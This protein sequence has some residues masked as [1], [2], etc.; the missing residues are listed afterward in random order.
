MDQ[1]AIGA[2]IAMQRRARGMTQRELA[3]RLAVSCQAVSKWEN[4]DNLPDSSLLLPL[5]EELHV[6]VDA[7]LS[8]GANR[9]RQPV[10]MT[11]LHTG[12]AAL[13]TA[14]TAL[15][16]DSAVGAAIDAA[17]Q[18]MGISLP[19]P[20]GR[21]KLL[22]EA[23]LHRLRNGAT[24]SDAALSPAI[25][26]EELRGQIRKCRWD[27]ALFVDKQRVY[28]DCRPGWPADVVTLIL[29]Q[30][31]EGAVMA[32]V[33]SGTGKLALLC[34]PHVR[35]L[36]A[37][38]PS[39]HMRSVLESRVEGLPQVQIVAASA[40]SI[41]LPEN[42]VDAI[43]VAEAYHWFDN[44]ATRR[45]FARILKPGG[46]VF[47]L[48]NRF[49]GNAYGPEMNRIQQQYRT[50]PGPPPRSREERA[51]DLFG[52]GKWHRCT[53]DNTLHQTFSQFL[54]GMS[55]ASY[56]PGSATAA[57][58]AYQQEIRTLFDAYA[59]DGLIT[60]HVTT[61]CWWGTLA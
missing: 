60:T 29:D 5:A 33:G 53:F 28:D 7:L 23:I 52:R 17:L 10:D 55:S 43:T 37:V 42:S 14:L 58:M 20:A 34:A 48:W 30:A 27:C 24:I 61:E 2:Y 21:E 19:D 15:G 47:L 11:V 39:I 6:T 35:R 12:V 36:Y 59:V 26:D 46:H 31:G 50:R 1:Q 45:E 18:S 9:P 44:E 41:P 8:A 16:R 56:A 57:G 51:D 4:G 54:G 49:T 32:D 38:E 25:R 3:G 22:T 40:E 13:E